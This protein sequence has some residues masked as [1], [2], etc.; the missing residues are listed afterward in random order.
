MDNVEQ[1]RELEDLYQ[2]KLAKPTHTKFLALGTIAYT[3]VSLSVGA[4]VVHNVGASPL[5]L[6]AA[7]GSGLGLAYAVFLPELKA[8]TDFREVKHN[9]AKGLNNSYA[10]LTEE[11]KT[12]VAAPPQVE[13][14]SILTTIGE[15]IENQF[16]KPKMR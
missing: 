11:E 15:K 12:L 5:G 2:K 7:I 10:K 3:G 13:P 16:H 14:K 9:F 1:Y 8:Y 4:I 6:A